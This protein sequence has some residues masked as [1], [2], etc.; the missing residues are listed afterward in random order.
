[1]EKRSGFFANSPLQLYPGTGVG[2]PNLGAYNS[3]GNAKSS[4]IIF[5]SS[6]PPLKR[7]WKESRHSQSL[8]SALAHRVLSWV[9]STERPLLAS[10]LIHGLAV[11]QKAKPI[12][13]EDMVSVKTILKV[14]GCPVGISLSY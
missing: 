12:D 3:Q 5:N 1:M 4:E 14:C 9:A 13:D 10:E 8:G 6:R 7:R 2:Q 11:D